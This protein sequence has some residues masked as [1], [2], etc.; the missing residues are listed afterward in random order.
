ME[1][2][3]FLSKTSSKNVVVIRTAIFPS[4]YGVI[5]I[6]TIANYLRTTRFLAFTFP[7]PY[8]VSFILIQGSCYVNKT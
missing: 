7:S 3:S 8:G 1:Y 2:H 5:F 4:P 6:L